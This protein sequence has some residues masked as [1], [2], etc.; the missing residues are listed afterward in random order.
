[1][2]KIPICK[3]CG[4][5]GHYSYN[6]YQKNKILYQREKERQQ[7]LKEQ[8]LFVEKKRKPLSQSAKREQ[9]ERRRLIRNL[10]KYCSWYVRLNEADKDGFITCITCGKKVYWK[11]ADNCHWLSRRYQKTRWDLRDV[12]AGCRECN[13]AKNGNYDSYNKVMKK[14]LGED[15]CAELEQLAHSGRKISTVELNA[16]LLDYKAKVKNLLKERKEKGWKC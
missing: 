4:K 12:H 9:T 16:M 15:G 8:G 7:K 6:C 11:Q 14:L 1:M 5:L 2:K 3:Y 10:D 13:R